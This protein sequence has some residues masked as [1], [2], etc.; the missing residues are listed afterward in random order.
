MTLTGGS[1]QFCL[2]IVSTGRNHCTEKTPLRSQSL[3]E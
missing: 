1:K 2:D 3:I